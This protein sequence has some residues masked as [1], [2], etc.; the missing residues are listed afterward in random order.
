[1]RRV[2]LFLGLLCF[3]AHVAWGVGCKTN[4]NYHPDDVLEQAR[5]FAQKNHGLNSDG[6]HS[7][8]GP[9]FV[10]EESHMVIGKNI[11]C[12]AVVR[13]YRVGNIIYNN[14]DRGTTAG[15]DLSFMCFGFAKGSKWYKGSCLMLNEEAPF[16][17]IGMEFKKNAFLLHLREDYRACA[18]EADRI[19]REN[20]INR[21]HFTFKPFKGRYVLTTLDVKNN[22][23]PID[24]VYRQKRDHMKIFMDT[25]EKNILQDLVERCENKGYC[26]EGDD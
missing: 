3:L 6:D 26:K 2:G 21:A 1:M 23:E 20:G 17:E 14:G 10:L 15:L 4:I 24:P 7:T 5:D 22:D 16:S 9:Q 25:I 11:Y 12:G 8:L 18:D 19:G 13:G